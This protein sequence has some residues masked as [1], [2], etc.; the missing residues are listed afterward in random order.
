MTDKNKDRH[1]NPNYKNE[2]ARANYERVMFMYRHEL[3]YKE[4]IKLAASDQG[5]SIN[6]WILRA[7]ENE[8]ARE[9]G[10]REE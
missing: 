10:L 5:L 7:I 2:Y 4:R 8:L 1:K 6:A 9:S 3:N